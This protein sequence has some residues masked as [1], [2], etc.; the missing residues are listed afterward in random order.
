MDKQRAVGN[1]VTDANMLD[2]YFIE[3]NKVSHDVESRKIQGLLIPERLAKLKFAIDEKKAAMRRNR[4]NTEKLKIQLRKETGARH[5]M[6]QRKVSLSPT[7]EKHR[8]EIS[9]RMFDYCLHLA[10]LAPIDELRKHVANAEKFRERVD[11]L[12]VVHSDQIPFYA[13]IQPGKQLFSDW[14]VQKSK[15]NKEAN[16]KN[17][18]QS[19][20]AL[21]SAILGQTS[22]SEMPDGLPEHLKKNVVS[23]P[24]KQQ[25][26]EDDGMHHIRGEATENQDKYRITVDCEQVYR[27]YADETKPIRGHWGLVSVTLAGTHL[28]FE[29]VDSDR[30][31]IREQVFEYNG[32][33]FRYQAGEKLPPALG[34]GL[35]EIRENVPEL[36]EKAHKAGIRFYQQPAGF[37]D[38]V[39]T[40]WKL[41]K[42]AQLYPCSIAVRDLFGG[43]LAESTRDAQQA[44]GQIPAFILGK[45][46]CVIQITDTDVA[47][48]LKNEQRYALDE[49]RAELTKLAELEGTRAIFR[50]GYY[51]VVRSLTQAVTSLQKKFE[52]KDTLVAAARRNGWM[53]LRPSLSQKKFVRCDEQDWC[54]KYKEGSH[55]MQRDWNENRYKW[56]DE[57]GLPT[58][59]PEDELEKMIEQQAH[60]SYWVESGH[61]EE[62]S[63]WR[64]LL[65][66]EELSAQQLQ[67]MKTTPYFECLV[68][69]FSH[70]SD[71]AKEYKELVKT[72]KQQRA[73]AGLDV[74]LTSQLPRDQAAKK[75][76]RHK[77]YREAMRPLRRETGKQMEEMYKKGFSKASVLK[78]IIPSAGK[79]GKLSK[80][81]IKDKLRQHT[82]KMARQKSKEMEAEKEAAAKAE[83]EKKEELQD[84]Q[85]TWVK[86]SSIKM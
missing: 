10:T 84:E 65:E 47:A 1:T 21:S 66:N 15:K 41:E 8:Y 23:R 76:Q 63:I 53:A 12:V 26:Y 80:A 3:A 14:E 60:D 25:F 81:Q 35:L 45:M 19:D 31:W 85:D 68:S 70:F 86:A 24:E 20:G 22:A 9:L 43:G 50:C 64:S 28:D 61:E 54:K 16:K 67:E 78:Q 74:N 79:K 69:E 33:E 38:A 77:R 27:N 32:R 18:F 36:W 46:G 6:P 83:E 13:K 59:V 73:E 49:L 48:A 51:E 72:P 4:R 37:E 62:L 58:P 57:A 82:M 52:D 71:I 75:F 11:E 56:L 2:Q 44:I 17:L 29:N 40:Y 30:R 7:E 39:I 42:Q 5:L 34:K 55:R